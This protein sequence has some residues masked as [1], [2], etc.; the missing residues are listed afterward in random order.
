MFRAERASGF[1]G[2]EGW[3]AGGTMRGMFRAEQG[4]LKAP[5]YG[6]EGRW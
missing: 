6:P 5:L 4:R 2:L 3:R 1:Y